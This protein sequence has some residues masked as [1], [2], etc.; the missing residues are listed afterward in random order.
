VGDTVRALAVRAQQ[1]GLELACHVSPDVPDHVVGDPGRLRQVLVNLV[2]NAIKFTHHG[3]VVVTVRSQESG[4]WGLEDGVADSCLLRFW[5]RDTGIGIPVDK[6]A[7]VFQPFEQADRSMTRR[8][9]GTGLG[10]AISTQL[11][12][13]MGGEITVSSTVG[14]GSTFTFTARLGVA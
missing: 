11:V 8:Y 4:V 3:E 14:Q 13:L 5:V 1:K 9:G 2:G 7:T 10:L 6:L 12:E